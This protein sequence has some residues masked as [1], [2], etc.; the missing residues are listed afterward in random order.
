LPLDSSKY[1]G[2]QLEPFVAPIARAD[3]RNPFDAVELPPPIKAATILRR[4]EFAPAY[5]YLEE[6]IR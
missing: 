4:G 3:W 6:Y 5:K 2:E 1:F